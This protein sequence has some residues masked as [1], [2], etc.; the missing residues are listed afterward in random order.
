VP[1]PSISGVR[2]DHAEPDPEERAA[3]AKALLD[4]K[5]GERALG[6]LYARW[7]A[8]QAKLLKTVAEAREAYGALVVAAGKRRGFL[9]GDGAHPWTFDAERLVFRRESKP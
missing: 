7:L 8:D 2:P 9:V 5:E 1:V 3:I 6:C 4:W